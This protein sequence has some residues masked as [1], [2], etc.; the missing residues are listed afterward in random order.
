MTVR[1]V[2]VRRCGVCR[3][4]AVAFGEAGVDG[5]VGGGLFGREVAGQDAEQE[6]ARLRQPLGERADD[7]VDAGDGLFGGLVRLAGVVGADEQDGDGGAQVVELAVGEAPEDVGGG[8][9]GEAEV[10]GAA[11][12]VE[13]LPGGEEVLVGRRGLVLVLDDG[14]ADEEEVDVGAGAEEVDD[15]LVTLGPPG[16]V[17]AGDGQDGGEKVLHGGARR[18]RS[19]LRACKRGEE[20]ERGGEAAEG[21]QA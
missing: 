6:D 8:V 1:D 10:E 14:V 19:A 16:L 3:P 9:A 12:S 11:R 13:L 20:A 7:V 2:G 15:V 4:V 17:E 5:L 18:G 21:M